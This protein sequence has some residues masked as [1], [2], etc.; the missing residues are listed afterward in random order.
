MYSHG[1]GGS[2]FCSFQWIKKPFILIFMTVYL[3]FIGDF[4]DLAKIWC[5]PFFAIDNES[6]WMDVE[7]KFLYLNSTGNYAVQPKS[8]LKEKSKSS[9]FWKG[10]ELTGFSVSSPGKQVIYTGKNCIRVLTEPLFTLYEY[11]LKAS[12]ED[13]QAAPN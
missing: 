7:N 3:I 12:G 4:R 11:I 9:R 1:A 13:N 5:N 8:H 10:R 2:C 6:I